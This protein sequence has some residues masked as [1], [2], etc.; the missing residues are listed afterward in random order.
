MSFTDLQ[1]FSTGPERQCP[2]QFGG[3]L[4]VFPPEELT[5]HERLGYSF[6]PNACLDVVAYDP[7]VCVPGDIK[8]TPGVYDAEV[9]AVLGVIQTAINCTTGAT[10]D[11]L[12]AEVREA[13]EN[14]LERAIEADFVTFLTTNA[15]PSGGPLEATCALAEAAQFL[16]NSGE[17]GRGIIVGPV[18]WLVQLGDVLVWHP[19]KGYHTD[20]VGNVV[21]AHSVDNDTVF[22]LD[23]A[24]DIKVSEVLLLDDFAPGIRIVNDRIMRAEQLY[25]IAV[26]SCSIASFTVSECCGCSSGGGG[27]GGGNV[28]V[29]N[30]PA[31]QDVNI[32]G[33][34]TDSTS[35]DD[36]CLQDDNG[37]F[38]RRTTNDGDGNIVVSLVDVTGTPYV[39]VGTVKACGIEAPVVK[40][41]HHMATNA[42]PW[43]NAL[44]TGVV[45]SVTYTVIDGTA[46]VTDSDSQTV[47][48]I[49]A[50][51]TA[52]WNNDLQGQL[53]PL[54]SV[55]PVGLSDRAYV[56]WTEVV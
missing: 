13:L 56:I 48:N 29:T 6:R 25:T 8:M 7:D 45:T 37:V 34:D 27:G 19:N 18:N 15:I 30:F 26:D 47:T 38:F 33:G 22:A 20:F 4:S 39:P 16:N 1:D 28:T 52:T 17:C 46:D 36:E 21:I 51:L 5:G 32:V 55:A 2:D 24:V 43:T 49:P 11:E 12:R 41:K 3:L 14:N 31:V 42:N 54:I 40:T 10:E 23:M 44:P 53:T 9:D 35:N 50:G